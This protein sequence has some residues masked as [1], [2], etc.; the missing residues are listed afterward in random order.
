[1][2]AIKFKIYGNWAHFKKS[3]TNNNPLTHDFITKTALIGLIGSVLGYD[4]NVMK[5]LF[6]QLCEDFLYGVQILNNVKKEPWGFTTRN[7]RNN[8]KKSR[9]YFEILKNPSNLIALSLLNKRSEEIFDLFKISLLNNISKYTPVLGLHNCPANLVFDS[10]GNF[11]D[12]KNGRFK[13]KC[14]ISKNHKLF[15]LN[16]L[17]FRIGFEKIPTYQNNDFWN[18]P[19]KFVEVIYCDNGNDIDVEGDYYEY[20]DLEKWWLI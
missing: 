19:E 5:E 13:A 3:E 14:I 7:V 20:N 8:L 2:K 1:M 6:P 15:K 9:K 4:R 10:E 16:E 18:L 17:N 11:S 12:K